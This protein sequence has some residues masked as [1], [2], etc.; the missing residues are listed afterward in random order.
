MLQFR[1]MLALLDFGASFA[2][3]LLC[4]TSSSSL[5]P[6]P[7]TAGFPTIF[8]TFGF[9][10]AFLGGMVIFACTYS[11]KAMEKA[12][13]LIGG[14]ALLVY[15]TSDDNKNGNKPPPHGPIDEDPLARHLQP[16]PRHVLPPPLHGESPGLEHLHAANRRLLPFQSAPLRLD[17]PPRHVLPPP[18]HGE[19]PGLEHLHAANRRLLPFES[20]PI[21]L[22]PPPRR[23]LPGPPPAHGPIDEDPL[24]KH[25]QAPRRRLL[26]GPIEH[27]QPHDP[28]GL[29]PL[30]PMRTQRAPPKIVGKPIGVIHGENQCARLLVPCVPNPG[31]GGGCEAQKGHLDAWETFAGPQSADACYNYLTTVP[32]PQNTKCAMYWRGQPI[33]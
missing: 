21:K 8:C 17:P 10:G 2:F 26:P 4:S 16:P 25:L 3:A 32:C 22:E 19:S 12:A 15:A 27:L 9:G 7:S 30:A 13:L 14:V 18:L 33:Q 6:S 20:A 23:V 24:A 5:A 31:R 29:V 1:T 11:P 28:L